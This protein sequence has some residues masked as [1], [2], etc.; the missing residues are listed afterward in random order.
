MSRLDNFLLV[1]PWESDV[2][3]ETWAEC[4]LAYLIAW[5]GYLLD[6][7]GWA[8]RL[9]EAG[10]AFALVLPH[11][12]GW[13]STETDEPLALAAYFPVEDRSPCWRCLELRF[14]GWSE[15]PG[16]D[17]A[18]FDALRSSWHPSAHPDVAA[19]AQGD[20]TPPHDEQLVM[21]RWLAMD[22]TGA[23][24]GVVMRGGHDGSYTLHTFVPHPLCNHCSPWAGAHV[25]AL[26]SSEDAFA[27]D[28]IG[29]VRSYTVP[30]G[31]IPPP[32][33]D[34]RSVTRRTFANVLP[35]RPRYCVTEPAPY[36]HGEAPELALARHQAPAPG[37]GH[38]ERERPERVALLEAVAAYT[39]RLRAGRP[40]LRGSRRGIA[41][42]A[43][44]PR[45]WMPHAGPVHDALT[46]YR[47]GRELDWVRG[48][49]LFNGDDVALCADLFFDASPWDGIMYHHLAG[50]VAHDDLEVAVRIA[51]CQVAA[52]D[53]LMLT[54][55]AERTPPRVS[56]SHIQEPRYRAVLEEAV[57]LGYEVAVLDLTTD[58]GVPVLAVVARSEAAEVPWIYGCGC[59]LDPQVA[60]HRAFVGL[61]DALDAEDPPHLDLDLLDRLFEGDEVGLR[62][63]H[64]QARS[65]P[66]DTWRAHLRSAE[67]AAFWAD[68]TPPDVAAV[69]LVV[70]KV[71]IAH[72][73]P[74]LEPALGAPSGTSR[75][76]QRL[77]RLG[78]A[79]PDTDLAPHPFYLHAPSPWSTSSTLHPGSSR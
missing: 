46:R 5:P 55:Y 53:A 40:M 9:H 50:T 70:V 25:S 33:D 11:P 1:G 54:W 20:I 78:L 39:A 57:R 31:R 41:A 27:D 21:L 67:T 65:A 66:I 56:W 74:G 64:P 35:P 38:S 69:G 59:D 60:L 44:D 77:A 73:L 14:L 28:A 23:D 17:A 7:P 42:S 30:S 4:S 76:Q 22:V 79:A 72:A 37:F 52:V 47:D 45:P 2:D 43:I 68:L 49:A 48:H 19:L 6:Y 3:P 29:V 16:H 12:R 63:A 71:L 62:P 26:A 51:L 13:Q 75:W 18:F 15:S 8:R 24:A 10:K 36:F 34:R 61:G 32:P 58:L